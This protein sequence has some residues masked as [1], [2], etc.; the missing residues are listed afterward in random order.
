MYSNLNNIDFYKNFDKINNLFNILNE[1]IK[2]DLEY[3]F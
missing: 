1:K 2:K 3:F